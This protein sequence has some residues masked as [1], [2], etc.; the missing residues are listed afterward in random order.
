RLA[1]RLDV[2]LELGRLLTEGFDLNRLLSGLTARVQ[3]KTEDTVLLT[4][5][6]DGVYLY[7]DANVGSTDATGKTT[8][9][10]LEPFRVL[11]GSLPCG[12]TNPDCIAAGSCYLPDGTT[13]CDDDGCDCCRSAAAEDEEQQVSVLDLI[14]GNLGILTNV[15]IS[16]NDHSKG[17]V[18][19]LA[20][21]T[22]K[23]VLNIIGVAA[24]HTDVLYDGTALDGVKPTLDIDLT[25]GLG[26]G[27]TLHFVD[28][29]PRGR[30]IDNGY[31]GF[32]VR[33]F[34]LAFSRQDISLPSPDDFDLLDLDGLGEMTFALTGKLVLS[35]D[36][37]EGSLTGN[38]APGTLQDLVTNLVSSLAGG[39]WS[40]AIGVP[41][42]FEIRTSFDLIANVNLAELDTSDI[43][44][45]VSGLL[46]NI[47]LLLNV[48]TINAQDERTATAIALYYD[49]RNHTVYARAPLFG[50]GPVRYDGLDLSAL[51]GG[52]LAG[53]DEESAAAGEVSNGDK[54]V[55]LIF[56]PDGLGLSVSGGL[57]GQALGLF[58]VDLG[59]LDVGSYLT[60]VGAGFT[61]S[62]GVSISAG[63]A[64]IGLKIAIQGINLQAGANDLSA[65]AFADVNQSEFA[66]LADDQG[67]L[68]LREVYAAVTVDLDI[69]GNLAAPGAELSGSVADLL[70]KLGLAAKVDELLAGLGLDQDVMSLLSL[71]K[72]YLG[73]D[74]DT[75]LTMS[76]KLYAD[77]TDLSSLGLVL[78]LSSEHFDLLTLSFDGR[79]DTIYVDLGNSTLTQGAKKFYIRGLGLTKLIKD[80]L[81]PILS[82]IEFIAHAGDEEES[83]LDILGLIGDIVSEI[84]IE[85]QTGVGTMFHIITRADFLDSVLGLVGLEALIGALPNV[86]VD[87]GAGFNTRGLAMQ[88]GV[89][90]LNTDD[91]VAVGLGVGVSGLQVAFSRPA[92][93]FGDLTAYVPWNEF[94]AGLSTKAQLSLQLDAE[95]ASVV[96]NLIATFVEGDGLRLSVDSE[97]GI[98]NFDVGLD[99]AVNVALGG[100]SEA[101]SGNLQTEVFLSAYLCSNG[102]DLYVDG[103][104]LFTLYYNNR[105]RHPS[106]DGTRTLVEE[107]LYLMFGSDSGEGHSVRIDD[108]GL[109]DAVLSLIFQP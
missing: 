1:I 64:G 40:T 50:V 68:S 75:H 30:E 11:I 77:L 88:V 91:T 82:G 34:A 103:N 53:G 28:T 58:G 74:L 61:T 97:S 32:G 49:G 39:T 21:D 106:A 44:G 87:L 101:S 6:F 31:V 20:K 13:R 89:D 24:L 18:I 17:I 93:F 42:S 48:Y 95:Y 104:R 63:V 65:I 38:A 3:V 41:E 2:N 26:V 10:R 29:D 22:L 62:G 5:W 96:N 27:M 94:N 59:G 47:Q 98:V 35:F 81:A 4:A 71:L 9:I 54:L 66:S 14:L 83:E 37:Q 52:L 92:D 105:D 99:L 69:L 15:T 85:G 46:Q 45:S 12:C 19:G 7:V 78:T 60:T 100:V 8:G 108:L 107:S 73:L 55:A 57:I 67:N 23:R 79:D 109:V 80:N 56:D 102:G 70:D 72:V 36:A 25:D 16:N 84:S 51:I 90:I 76:V 86:T 33:N 43:A